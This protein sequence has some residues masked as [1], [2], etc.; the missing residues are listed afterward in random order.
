MRALALLVLLPILGA[1][2]SAVETVTATPAVV[3]P[4]CAQADTFV[5]GIEHLGD[6][7]LFRVR[8]D[9]ASPSVPALGLNTWNLAV[10]A[11]GEAAP[12]VV[13][14]AEPTMPT[15]R[16]G[17]IPKTQR[18]VTDPAGRAVFDQLNLFKP[19]LWKI[20][21]Y[22]TGVSGHSDVLQFRFCIP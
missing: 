14:V 12:S 7:G 17:T 3:D 13:L 4:A 2:C 22:A 5:P 16:H 8:I 19:G 6:G 15:Y 20:T 10:T 9:S 21:M 18:V 1:T 11:E